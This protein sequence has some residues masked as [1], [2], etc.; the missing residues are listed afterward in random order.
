MLASDIIACLEQLAPPPLQESYDNSG[1]LVGNAQRQVKGVLVSLDCTEAVI[2]DALRQGCDMVVCH[3]PIIFSGLKRLNGAN[4][5]ERTVMKAIREDVLI[6][7]IHTNLDNVRHGVNTRIAE[8]IGLSDTKVL[9]PV[10]GQLR[11]LVTY[12]PIA[13]GEQV[14]WA[15]WQAGAGHIG[16]YDLCSFNVNGQGTF[17]GDGTTDPFIGRPN[18][19][20]TVEEVRIE[21]IFPKHLESQLLR[22]L[23]AAHPCEEVAYDILVT[24]N[25]WQDVGAGLV[26]QLPEAVDTL[27]F[28]SSL[29]EKMKTACVRHTPL[30]KQKV[31]RIA[32]CGGAGSFLIKDAI[33]AGA[34]VL[35]TSDIKY[36]QF[37]D[38]DERLVIADIGHFESEQFTIDLLVDHLKRQFPTFATRFPEVTTN[39]INYL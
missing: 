16:H 26:G 35:I 33:R 10:R 11:K 21:V 2:N 9:A 12:A 28:L 17:R 37:F 30:L 8:R 13:H 1:L 4:Y 20:E 29:K 27:S 38:A 19:M 5:V 6:Y 3:H 23:R 18:E 31:Q 15:L 25:T 32:V 14:R 36:H 39:P 22:A 34:D 24:D 7:A